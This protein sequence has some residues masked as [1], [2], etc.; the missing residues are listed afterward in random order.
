MAA[1]T[2]VGVSANAGFTTTGSWTAGLPVGVQSGDLLVAFLG[3]RLGSQTVN[4][5][6]GYTLLSTDN[7]STDGQD[8]V[9][10]QA[11]IA[12]GSESAPGMST[13]V[14]TTQ[15]SGGILIAIRGWSGT[16]GDL[17]LSSP[18]AAS[19]ATMVA[20]TAT[21]TVNDSL[22]LRLYWQADDNAITTPP[23]SHTQQFFESSILGSD[24]A[25]SVFSATQTTAGSVGT[26]SLVVGGADPYTAWTLIVPPASGTTVNGSAAGSFGF[27]GTANGLRTVKGAVTGSFGFSGVANGKRTVVGSASGAFGFT[28]VATGES[29]TPGSD[30]TGSAVGQFG[31]SGTANGVRTVV[32]Q[33]SGNFGFIGTARGADESVP[34]QPPVIA[35]AQNAVVTTVTTVSTIT[36]RLGGR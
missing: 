36:S 20:P 34:A 25:I 17:I 27:T 26:A 21:S 6:S 33:A 3:A 7:Y 2:I 24:A 10:V 35:R 32:G 23:G 31:F 28:G 14:A 5:T 18:N 22:V 19:S 15:P 11:K 4:L 13:S 8:T 1:P 12:G 9:E 29:E 16:L 30:I